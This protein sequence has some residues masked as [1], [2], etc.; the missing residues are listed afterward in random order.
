MQM[1]R[2]MN[3]TWQRLLMTMLPVFLVMFLSVSVSVSADHD[4]IE[5]VSLM[6]SF[7]KSPWLSSDTVM[8]LKKPKLKMKGTKEEAAKDPGAAAAGAVPG[9]A[10]PGAGAVPGAAGPGAAGAAAG[11]P[12]GAPAGAAEGPTDA[13][14]VEVAGPDG[15]PITGPDKPRFECE[16]LGKWRI[17]TPNVGVSAMQLQTMPFDK[18]VW[19]DT[20]FLGASALQWTPPGNCPPNFET[21]QPDCFVHSLEYDA[22]KDTTRPLHVRG[23]KSVSSVFNN[24]YS[25]T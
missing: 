25:N 21:N 5:E 20:T 7:G 15:Q 11:E 16:S 1:R 6:Q 22:I 4:D 14:A 8:K 17:T 9:A 12:A 10:G 19:F 23:Y 3:Y 2:E 13:L 24:I 18:L